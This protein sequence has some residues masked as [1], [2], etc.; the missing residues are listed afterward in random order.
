MLGASM[1][2]MLQLVVET[3]YTQAMIPLVSRLFEFPNRV[4]K[5]KSLLQNSIKRR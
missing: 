3:H 2:D 1:S 5:L 4:D